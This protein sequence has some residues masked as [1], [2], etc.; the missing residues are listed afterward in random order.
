MSALAGKHALV[1]GGSRGIG[2]A[3]AAAL[4][5][6]GARVTLLARNEAMLQEAAE[7]LGKL[8]EV[9]YA[10][11]DVAQ[12][13]QVNEAFA[14][15]RALRGAVDI[16][17]N[18]AGYAESAPFSKTGIKLWQRMLDV[19][20]NGTFY[21]SQAALPAM[22]ESGWGRIVN[23]ASTAGLQGYPYVAAYC[24]AKHGV[25]GL[26]R[27]LA[28]ELSDS[29]VTVNAVCP[30]YTDTPMLRQAIQTLAAR[31]GQHEDVVRAALAAQNAQGR[32]LLPEEVA[33]KVMQFCLPD[34]AGFNGE[35]ASLDDGMSA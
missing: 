22:R 1:T 33:Q 2:E 5:R 4:L 3:V 28:Q 29:G 25:I 18:N 12:P 32:L 19:N 10:V 35:V 17:I 15:A 9:A 26:T 6:Q 21:C 8:G 30:G 20:L 7:H 16:L 31:T 13:G 34:A 27:A 14:T 23:I 11:A 24:A